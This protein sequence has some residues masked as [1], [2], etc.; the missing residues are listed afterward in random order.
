MKEHPILFNGPMVVATLD[1]HKTQ[2]R[3][4]MRNISGPWR[5]VESN[6]SE[7][8][9]HHP[10][11][12]DEYG[13][14]HDMIG[15]FGK[16]GDVLYV[17]HTFWHLPGLSTNPNNEQA[18]DE[19]TKTVRFIRGEQIKDCIVNLEERGWEKR[20]SIHMPKWASIIKLEVERVWV[21]PIQDISDD[22]AILEGLYSFNFTGWG[23]EPHLP[24]FPE[25]T[26]YKARPED[27]WEESPYIAFKKL[28]DSIY[29]KRGLGWEAN[30]YVWC[31]EFKLLEVNNG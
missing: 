20:P 24:S 8:E 21:E 7:E 6:W 4:P 18:W 13:D 29:N 5:G 14:F 9:P 26:V 30:P 11:I 27:D 31:C 23:D 15:P 1:S 17:R 28:W 19:I 2:T 12:Q 16:P 10:Y 22:N 25:P 3:R